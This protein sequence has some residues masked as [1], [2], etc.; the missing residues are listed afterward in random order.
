LGLFS[1]EVFRENLDYNYIDKEK[2]MDYNKTS[3][4]YQ[5]E[6]LA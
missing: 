3:G 1:W 4:N 6:K 2:G 5:I